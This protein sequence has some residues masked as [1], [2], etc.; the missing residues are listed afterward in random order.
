LKTV[1]VNLARYQAFDLL[2][3]SAPVK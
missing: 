1:L 2:D 3:G